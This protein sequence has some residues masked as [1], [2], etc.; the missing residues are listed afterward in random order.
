MFAAARIGWVVTK[1]PARQFRLVKAL[2]VIGRE[3]ALCDIALSDR[4]ISA[5]HAT[6]RVSPEGAIAITDE[7][8]QNGTYVNGSRIPPRQA[9]PLAFDNT[10]RMGDTELTLKQVG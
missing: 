6:I 7:G 2:T 4:Y 5:R 10:I 1:A 9:I 3:Q 8:S